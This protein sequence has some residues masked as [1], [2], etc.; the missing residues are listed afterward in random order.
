MRNGKTID[1]WEIGVVAITIAIV[2]FLLFIPFPSNQ[3]FLFAI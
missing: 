1:S 3:S 2:P